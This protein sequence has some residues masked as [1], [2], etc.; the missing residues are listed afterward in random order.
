MKVGD[1]SRSQGPALNHERIV[2]GIEEM[3]LGRDGRITRAVTRDEN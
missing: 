3:F 2:K 1:N